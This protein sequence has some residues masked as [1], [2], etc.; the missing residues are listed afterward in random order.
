MAKMISDQLLYTFLIQLLKKWRIAGTYSVRKVGY[1]TLV[2]FL[3]LS[4]TRAF[5]FP[6]VKIMSIKK[7]NQP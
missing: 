1:Y 5:S 3:Y 6:T 4:R 7:K 2:L